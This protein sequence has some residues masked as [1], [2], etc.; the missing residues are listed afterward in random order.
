MRP[1][2]AGFMRILY[3]LLVLVCMLQLAP[4]LTMFFG[5]QGMLP[6][7]AS[8][9]I[10][11]SDT[12]TIF[13]WLPR[14][15]EA[16]WLVYGLC[17]TQVVLLGVGLFPRFQA[18]CVFCW[19]VSF[20][21]RNIIMFDGE[22][23]LLRLFGFFLI[24][25]PLHRF[26]LS[27]L[28][29]P[30]KQTY[31]AVWP[32]RLMQIQLCVIYLST[33][34]EKLGG[35]AWRDGTAMYFI[36]RLDDFFGRFPVPRALIEDLWVIRTVT[37]GT[38]VVELALP[39]FLWFRGTRKTALVVA[40]LFHLGIDY[41]MNLFLFHWVMLYGLIAFLMQ[42]SGINEEVP[43]EQAVPTEPAA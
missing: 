14:N 6:L 35:V 21:H 4:D 8:R 13:M 26:A 18:V 24:F 16:L 39:I 37:W 3:A 20:H 2:L 27:S 11:D 25:M 40:V 1:E 5:E 42:P 19:L 12:R 22:D 29:W 43:P 30:C 38:L 28:I 31:F 41:C 34:I 33:A 32:M 7:D 23:I 10:I 36:T 17:L 9:A 15:D